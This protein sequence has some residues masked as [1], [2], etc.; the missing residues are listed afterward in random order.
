MDTKK[1]LQEIR[2]IIREEIDYALTKKI[3]QKQTKKDDIGTLK[4][5]IS[6]FNES[7]NAKKLIL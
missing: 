5:G 6:I 4:H 3:S 1:F 7:Q 2:S